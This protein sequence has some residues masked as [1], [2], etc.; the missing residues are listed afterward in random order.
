MNQKIFAAAILAAATSMSTS[1]TA[2]TNVTVYGL[3]D[4]GLASVSGATANTHVPTATAPAYSSG[5]EFKMRD[6]I[7]T[8][9]RLG[10][11]GTE[12]LGDGAAA[13]FVLEA[14]VTAD[15]G[16]SDQG[17]V[18]FGRQAFVGLKSSNIGTLTLGRQYPSHYL[19]FKAIDPMDDGMAGAAGNLL[20]TNGKRVNN[21]IK[22]A[23][24]TN[25]GF[26]GDLFYA[27]G[28]VAGDTAASRTLG[29]SLTY[30][31]GPL[32]AKAAYHSLE[33][34]TSTDKSTNSLIGGMYDFGSIRAHA[35]YGHNKGTGSV[36]NSDLL[37]GLSV[38]MGL[39]SLMASWIRKDDK[40]SLNRDAT[41]LA[42][43]YTYLFSKRT[44]LYASW[45]NINNDN[46]ATYRTASATAPIAGQTGAI[47]GT[48]E[49][50]VGFRQQF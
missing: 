33:N 22:Y 43:A 14:G 48:R 35:S 21:M 29:G 12:D 42:L 26:S 30:V 7:Q 16:A 39:H 20:P 4:L 38:P 6:G 15:T 2:Q 10:F 32:T 37:L 5:N 9:S 8:G 31:A 17:G 13:L 34:A 44:N 11:K 3:I 36:D 18:M 41:Q 28:E 23:T 1:A 49:F 50:N 27:L 19:A 46:G 45:A 24:P 47:G 25:F 40:S